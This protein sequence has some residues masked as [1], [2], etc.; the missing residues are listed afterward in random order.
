M[1]IFTNR[2]LELLTQERTGMCVSLFLRTGVTGS[3]VQQDSINFNNML[4]AIQEE[5]VALGMDR[6]A[7]RNFIK[8]ARALLSDNAFW[9][10]PSKGLALFLAE[11]F[12]RP[13]RL[14]IA[15][16]DMLVV[17]GRF[18]LKPLLTLLAGD[19]EYYLLVLSQSKIRLF[20]GS[21]FG[22]AKV[23]VPGVPEAMKE[24]VSQEQ[25]EAFQQYQVRPG[26]GTPR[27]ER[28][29]DEN[30]SRY[31]PQ[32]NEGLHGLLRDKSS[33][34]VIAGVE[35]LLSLYRQAN[36]YPGLLPG[37]IKG[38]LDALRAEALHEKAWPLVE[39]LLRRRRE[40]AQEELQRM[41]S[42]GKAS[43]SAPEIVSASY[44]G[45]VSILLV[46]GR[47]H[48]WGKVDRS[49]GATVSHLCRREE[50]GCEDLYDFAAVHTLL[51]GGKVYVL[52]GDP[53]AKGAPIAA[54]FR[55]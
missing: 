40:E 9:Q 21:R 20:H 26:K 24:A 44:Q 27:D 36:T 11:G 15:F 14:P 7:A 25:N 37:E 48:E 52:E 49:K 34:L 3:Q 29:D 10:F 2:D 19:S 4:A 46:S 17:A 30:I 23:N 12:F 54:V 32:V 8:P 16:D 28:R 47:R 13:Y 55:H 50:E 5:L 38:N 45:R 39:P 1:D 51:K 53:A 35:Y 43:T 33:P 6:P 41:I 31:F 22:L 18:H 42:T